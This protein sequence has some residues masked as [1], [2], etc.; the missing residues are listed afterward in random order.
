MTQQDHSSTK[1]RGKKTEG[2]DW[3]KQFRSNSKIVVPE[4]DSMWRGNRAHNSDPGLVFYFK[5]P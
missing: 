2:F 3:M 5:A 1:P 4:Q